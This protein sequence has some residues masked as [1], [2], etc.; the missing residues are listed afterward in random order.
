MSE[1]AIGA[2]SGG[3]AGAKAGAQAGNPFAAIIG[4]TIGTGIGLGA[5]GNIKRARVNLENT[6][7]EY[8]NQLQN[9]D[10][11]RYEDLKLALERYARGE[12]LSPEQLQALQDVDSE[13]QKIAQDK[14]AKETQLEALA[15]L[16][17]RSRGGLTL[18][19]KAD[20]LN[21]QREID[22][23]QSGVQ[24]SI[25]QNMAARGQGGSGAELA[26]RMM[27]G[28]S[29]AQQASQNSLNVAAQAQN[30]AYQALKDSA[31]LGRQIGQ[32]QLDFDLM[33]AK[34]ADETR[35]SNLERL[36]AAMQ[37]NIGNKNNA[38]MMNWER[39]N[40]VADKNVDIGNSEQKHNKDLL[41]QDYNNQID[42]LK[43]LYEGPYG[44][45]GQK[46]RTLERRGN[47]YDAW[48]GMLNSMSSTPMDGMFGGGGKSGPSFGSDKL[49]GEGGSR[50]AFSSNNWSF[51]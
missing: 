47:E 2:V 28:Q 1:D 46:Q 19:D 20:L 29:G 22:R 18:Q 39:A 3:A 24:K 21:A 10:M 31:S 26:A 43:M 6:I 9:L 13:V 23:Q 17:A 48:M 50:S 51:D 49:M 5:G 25:M 16:K 34:A 15:G 36:Q 38:N 8:M 14:T 30:R 7:A 41:M 12:P 35:R 45:I 4:A 11:P 33:K 37:Y 42:R 32:D 40:R 27:A 44:K